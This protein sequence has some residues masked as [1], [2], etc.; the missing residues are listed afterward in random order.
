VKLKAS[1]LMKMVRQSRRI[2][3]RLQFKEKN[4]GGKDSDGKLGCGSFTPSC[5]HLAFNRYLCQLTQKEPVSGD[6][7]GLED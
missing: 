6:K 4:E 5:T 7:A 1:A 3:K 2:D